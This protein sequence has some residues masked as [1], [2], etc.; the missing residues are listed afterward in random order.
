MLLEY[1]KK[2]TRQ[3][4]RFFFFTLLD[5][6][7]SDEKLFPFSEVSCKMKK[8]KSVVDAGDDHSIENHQRHKY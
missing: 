2:Y 3:Y 4:F 8:K 7:I 5:Q 6:V 1:F